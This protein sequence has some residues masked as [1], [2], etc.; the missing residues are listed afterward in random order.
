VTP[1]TPRGI[2][3]RG[4]AELH[5]AGG[6]KFGPGW[7]SAWIRIVPERIISWGID[8]AAFSPAGRHARSIT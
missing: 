3:V 4:R 1:W 8:G 6:E 5:S 2:E 7:D